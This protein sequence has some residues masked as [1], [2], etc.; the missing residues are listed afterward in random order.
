MKKLAFFLLFFAPA[1]LLRAQCFEQLPSPASTSWSLMAFSPTGQGWLAG[2]SQPVWHTTNNGVTWG[3]QDPRTQV[4]L[5]AIDAVD[6]EHAWLVGD[7]GVIRHTDNGGASWRQQFSPL[8][9]D[10]HAVAF[11]NTQLGL[12]AGECGGLMRSANG[13]ATWEWANANTTNSIHALAWTDSQVAIAAGANGLLRRSTDG[14]L[15]WSAVAGTGNGDHR[16]LAAN[17]A[18]VWVSGEGGT[19]YS[20]DAGQTWS[21]ATN[22]NFKSLEAPRDG[23]AI[24]CTDAGTLHYTENVMD[25]T[26]VSAFNGTATVVDFVSP[27]Q[28]YVGGSDGQIW[29]VTWLGAISVDVQ[30]ANCVGNTAVLVGSIVDDDATYTWTLPGGEE[31]AGTTIVVV[32]TGEAEYLYTVELGNCQEQRAVLLSPSPLPEVSIGGITSLCEGESTLLSANT[33]AA[34]Y[35]WSTGASSPQ[36]SVSEAGVY[37][38][39]A[40]NTFGCQAADTV[41]VEALPI[42]TATA[43]FTVCEGESVEVFGQTFSAVNPT[44]YALSPNGASNGCDSVVFVTLDISPSD[45]L[46]LDTLVCETD[47]PFQYEGT[48]VDGGGLYTIEQ[49]NSSGC[50]DWL[51]LDVEVEAQPV[52]EIS[53]AICEGE[54]YVWNGMELSQPG[55]Y[56][57]LILLNEGCDSLARLDL[58]VYPTPEVVVL[59]SLPDDGSGNGQIVAGANNGTPPFTFSWSNGSND[60]V[61]DNLSAGE[62]GLTVTDANGCTDSLTIELPRVTS[63]RT[64]HSTLQVNVWPNP[65]PGHFTV[66]LPTAYLARS[67]R[68]ELYSSSGRKVNSWNVGPGHNQIATSQPAG[69][70]WLRL[71]DE[72]AVRARRKLIISK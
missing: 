10:W 28:G 44:G 16:V 12:V 18:E 7:R 59:D 41:V 17:G 39:T 68:L 15:S 35:E 30:P 29:R 46:R 20:A 42:D 43:Q 33:T 61:N 51:L 19:Y 45:T 56:E 49:G 5:N 63:T 13:G 52:S 8:G 58:T 60:A 62:Y 14:G 24:G 26:T 1:L 27:A 6:G 3:P 47:L 48:E 71:V 67:A 57:L 9:G 4:R 21:F 55:G 23:H 69:L 31:V 11:A 72:K 40:T 34:N 66:E 54:T 50:S 22:L 2:N 36:L 25:W 64:S 70:Y 53:A 37:S 38:L 32:P 65:T